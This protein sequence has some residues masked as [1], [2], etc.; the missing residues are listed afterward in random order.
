MARRV[1]RRAHAEKPRKARSAAPATDQGR[2]AFATRYWGPHERSADRES[3]PHREAAST[4]AAPPRRVCLVAHGAEEL[5][6]ATLTKELRVGPCPH[7]V[8][9]FCVACDDPAR[10]TAAAP[11]PVGNFTMLPAAPAT[12]TSNPQLFL[13]YTGHSMPTN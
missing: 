13:Q 7:G 10:L 3:P 11:A 1:S 8:I 6:M 12:L 5:R 4:Q 9:G 2:Y